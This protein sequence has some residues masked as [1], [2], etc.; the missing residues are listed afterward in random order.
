[1]G[2]GVFCQGFGWYMIAKGLPKLPA[3]QAGL[4]ILTQPALSF[5]WDV[6]FLGRPT[7]MLGYCGA[8]LVLAA[9]CLGMLGGQRK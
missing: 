3:S 9:I 1:M 7:S 5:V 2:Y 4:I 6:L 8:V